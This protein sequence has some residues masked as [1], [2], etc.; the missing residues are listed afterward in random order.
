MNV[1]EYLFGRVRDAGVDHVFGIPGDFVVPHFEAAERAG[2]SIVPTAHE[3]GAGFAADAYARLR[4]LGMVLTTFGAG[5]LN[6]VNAIAQAYAEKS[7]VLVVSGAPEVQGRRIDALFHHRVKSYDSQ[8]NVYREVTGAAAA[9]NDPAVAVEAIDAVL[10]V[11]TC[12][13]R[14]GYIEIPRDIL[15]AN[16][17]PAPGG[18]PPRP[19]PEPAAV[20]EAMAEASDR[21]RRSTS[22]VVYAGVETERFRLRADLIAVVER[23]GVPVVTSI[24]GKSVFPEY[25]PNFVGIYMGQ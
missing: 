18:R 24:E 17:R 2:F 4:G 6:M 25:H 21:I 20:Q 16:V 15:L 23:L 8:L 22:P 5:A 14:P 19:Q 13:K 12:T 7:P 10:D 3:P 9:L 11:V 1:G